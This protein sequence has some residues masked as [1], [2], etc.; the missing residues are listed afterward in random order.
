MFFEIERDIKSQDIT[1]RISSRVDNY[2]GNIKAN[3]SKL[4]R[5]HLSLRNLVGDII[6]SCYSGILL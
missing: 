6:S 2:L 4:F 1:L 5:Y 3:T